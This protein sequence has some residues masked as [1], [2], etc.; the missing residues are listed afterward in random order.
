ML[1]Y[2]MFGHGTLAHK[3]IVSQFHDT[4]APLSKN[5]TIAAMAT[6]LVRYR[7]VYPFQGDSRASQLSFSAGDILS[8][9]V[10]RRANGGWLWGTLFG[11]P[12]SGWCP[13]SYLVVHAPQQN[14]ANPAQTSRAPAPAPATPYFV[15]DGG[16]INDGFSGPIMGG[17]AG[18]HSQF[19]ES[20]STPPLRKVSTRDED[21]PKNPFA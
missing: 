21:A 11:S 3:K 4:T 6:N 8:V 12:R 2:C 5:T 10:A 16:E 20:Q 9:D 18:T 19:R 7:A 14:Y 15:D 17:S 13:E 1:L